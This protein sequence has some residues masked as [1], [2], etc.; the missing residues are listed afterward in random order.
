MFNRNLFRSWH[1]NYTD[2]DEVPKFLSLKEYHNPYL[3]MKRFFKCNSIDEWKVLLNH[4]LHYAFSKSSILVEIS[5]SDSLTVQRRLAGLIEAVH[6]IDVREN[7]HVGGCLKN[8]ANRT[9]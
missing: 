9:S 1:A 3:G 2:W 7:T 6:L 5:D 4:I 8:F